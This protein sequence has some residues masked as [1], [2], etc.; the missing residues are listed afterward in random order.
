MIVL[1][2]DEALFREALSFTERETSFAARLIEKDYFCTVLL[3]FLVSHAA[4]ELVFKGGTCL[5]KIHAGF[6]RLSEDLDFAISVPVDA[7]RSKRSAKAAPIKAIWDAMPKQLSCFR[8][9]APLRGANNSTQ[10]LGTAQYRSFVT[11]DP[12]NITIDVA[13]REPFLTPIQDGF[14]NTILLDPITGREAV[15]PVMMRCISKTEAQAEKARAA[16]TRRDPAIRDYYD[17]DYAARKALFDP[18]EPAFIELVKRK[19]SIPGNA[20]MD[21]S[22]ERRRQLLRQVETKLRPVLKER[23]YRDFDP[24]RA[25]KLVDELARALATR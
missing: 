23:G 13:L 19:L 12:E 7:P 9:T 21:V 22:E 3:E 8:V 2:E 16:L 5:A 10:Y 11:A 14:A 6:Y 17:L 1:H 18:A 20:P 4:T 25:I 24:Q 15:P